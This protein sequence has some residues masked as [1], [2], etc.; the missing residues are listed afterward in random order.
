M[1]SNDNQI[2]SS[3]GFLSSLFTSS[4]KARNI[5]AS[6]ANT[7]MPNITNFRTGLFPANEN[8]IKDAK[9]R[10]A[11]FKSHSANQKP[12]AQSKYDRFKT[13][14]IFLSEK[15][16]KSDL[17]N[18]ECRKSD[19]TII[20]DSDTPASSPSRNRASID[21][22]TSSKDYCS[23]ITESLSSPIKKE[24]ENKETKTTSKSNAKSLTIVPHKCT[25]I[26]LEDGFKKMEIVN[27]PPVCKNSGL[28]T[29]TV[30]PGQSHRISLSHEQQVNAEDFPTFDKYER[31]KARNKVS[32]SSLSSEM[33]SNDITVIVDETVTNSLAMSKK[34]K[35]ATDAEN[36]ATALGL[37]QVFKASPHKLTNIELDHWRNDHN[38][39]IPVQIQKQALYTNNRSDNTRSKVLTFTREQQC[40]EEGRLSFEKYDRFKVR[41]K[42][43]NNKK[44]RLS[45]TQ[46]EG[47][48]NVRSCVLSL[49]NL[50]I[51]A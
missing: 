15:T 33:S 24:L 45:E 8:P 1:S 40:F 43:S 20:S 27:P 32:L 31:F 47:D 34:S 38:A 17:N 16:R 50:T 5:E 42:G 29:H 10:I 30:T 48:T 9:A 3:K 49:E 6:D 18:D 51:S 36:K 26:E 23:Y 22:T 13:R 19:A 39:E 46:K 14:N 4:H 37:F 44:E 2:S 41:N 25:N 21:S 7:I 12:V 35:A 11:L 28:Y